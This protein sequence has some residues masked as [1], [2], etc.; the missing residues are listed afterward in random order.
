MKLRAVT[1]ANILKQPYPY[2][3]TQRFLVKLTL[4]VLFLS[5]FFVYLFEPFNVNPEEH[6]M[7]YF[8][9]SLFHVAV[10]CFVFY[11]S[12]S[13]ANLLKIEEE[14][15]TVGKE[16]LSLSIVLILMGIANF[17]IRDL[18]YNNPNNWST[19]YLFEEIRNTFLVG[20]IIISILVPMNFARMYNRNSQKAELIQSALSVPK[21]NDVSEIAVETHL[22]SDDF[23]LK[24]EDFIFAKAE[25]NYL[26]F[27]LITEGVNKKLIK[28]I[29]IKDLESQLK[30]F[31]WIIRTH[32]SFLVNMKKVEAVSGNAQGYQLSLK[33]CVLTVPVSRGLVKK[34]DEAFTGLGL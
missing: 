11:S 15:W 6:K 23:L 5:F 31:P 4:G 17:L 19:S 30:H 10:S 12:F 28:R 1:F 21:K 20:L 29:T 18:L 33:H 25:G 34:F 8:W 14:K 13:I 7:S 22:K 32:R 26:E 24:L 3:F 9:I 27:H 2:Y 16:I